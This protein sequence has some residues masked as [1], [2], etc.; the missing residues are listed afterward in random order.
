M[1]S[2]NSVQFLGNLT[3]DC[4]VKVL[5]NGTKVANFTVA[6]S[7]GGYKTSDGRDIP[8]STQFH[9]IVAWRGL[10]EVCEKLLHK[11]DSVFVQGRIEYSEEEKNGVK[12]RYTDILA[13]DISLCHSRQGAQAAQAQS[14]P[15]I[16][17]PA[18]PQGYT[19]IFQAAPQA[20]QVQQVWDGTQYVNAYQDPTTGQWIRVN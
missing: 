20:P 4:D 15:A 19:P 8:E 3:K 6:T 13:E 17:Q 5:S 7:T 11:G 1:K 12:V 18:Q 9:R 16:Q 14:Q 10:A 2:V